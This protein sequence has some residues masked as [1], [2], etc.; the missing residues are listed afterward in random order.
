MRKG[1]VIAL[2]PWM[3]ETDTEEWFITK[4]TEYDGEELTVVYQ[5]EEVSFPKDSPTVH[6]QK[7]AKH[8]AER[9]IDWFQNSNYIRMMEVRKTPSGDI[10]VEG[11]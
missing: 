8:T 1:D 3:D 2:G 6:T 10:Q 4:I 7:T 9:M 11:L 5:G